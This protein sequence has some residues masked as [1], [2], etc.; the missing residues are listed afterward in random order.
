[1]VD[2]WIDEKNRRIEDEK[3]W[4]ELRIKTDRETGEPYIDVLIGSKTDSNIKS[5]M[6]LYLN[7]SHR[8]IDFRGHIKAINRKIVSKNKG[9]LKDETVL[10][11]DKLKDTFDVVFSFIIEGSTG[12]VMVK[13]FEFKE[14]E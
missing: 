4:A 10:L 5:H 7:Q 3:N 8:F 14:T 2:L 11:N 1:M 6:G 9:L 13:R 12:E